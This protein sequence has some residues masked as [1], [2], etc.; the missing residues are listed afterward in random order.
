MVL[1]ALIRPLKHDESQYVAAAVLTAHGQMLY[2]DF[3]YLQTPLQP[4]LFAPLAW[5]FGAGRVIVIDE[6]EYRLDFARRYCPAE[7][8]NFREIADM[9]ADVLDGL[10]T[11]GV[12]GNGDIERQ[13]NERVRALCARFPIYQG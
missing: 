4:F 12:E 6:I 5:L 11:N 2:C 7:V 9:V 8:Y 1:L 3:A 13:V 10:K